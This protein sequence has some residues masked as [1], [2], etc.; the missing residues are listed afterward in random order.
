MFLKR[1]ILR[2]T[3]SDV[4]VVSLCE[5]YTFRDSLGN[6]LLEIYTLRGTP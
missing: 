3:L 1:N 5:G 2:V 6:I 4:C